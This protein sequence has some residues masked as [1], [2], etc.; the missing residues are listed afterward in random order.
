MN[1][2]LKSICMHICKWQRESAGLSCVLFIKLRSHFID[3][4]MVTVTRFP[5]PLP[6]HFAIFLWLSL[7]AV[8]LL[9]LV[10]SS[11]FS[12]C[13]YF[14]HCICVC[15]RWLPSSVFLISVLRSAPLKNY[16]TESTPPH[17]PPFHHLCLSATV[18]VLL[19]LPPML[20][21]SLWRLLTHSPQIQFV[22]KHF[23]S[24]LCSE[25]NVH[26]NVTVTTVGP[27]FGYLMNTVDSLNFKE[28][29]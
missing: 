11:P 27:L 18:S 13:F 3:N 19:C 9:A 15:F 2:Y 6:L 14:C 8:I 28:K 22:A 21:V 20:H 10:F 26:E 4:F 12:F 17:P 1:L 5:F 24:F 16:S 29:F 23:S 7:A 25:L